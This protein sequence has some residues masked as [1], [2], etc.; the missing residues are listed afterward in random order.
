MTIART[1][2]VSARLGRTLTDEENRQV[3]VLLGDAEVM[4]RAR[5]PDLLDQVDVGT[6]SRDAVVMV[7][8]TMV[9]RVIRNPEGF[10][11]ETDG[12]YSYTVD[13]AVASG[14]LV[15]LDEEWSLLGLRTRVFTIAPRL[16][17]PAAGGAWPGG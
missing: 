12:S 10:T 4:L 8:A 1:V 15:V 9:T 6:I 11:Q 14:R 5:I 17:I 16:D 7:E 2:D 3:E 13:S